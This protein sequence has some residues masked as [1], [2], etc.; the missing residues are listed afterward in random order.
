MGEKKLKR[1]EVSESDSDSLADEI[2]PKIKKVPKQ[3]KAKKHKSKHEKKKNS[4]QVDSDSEVS[5]K[6]RKRKKKKHK[7]SD[8][9]D[10]ED[11]IPNKRKR[12]T[13][14]S[15]NED[16]PNSSLGNNRHSVID[17][18]LMPESNEEA[19][20][21]LLDGILKE[22]ISTSQDY[23]TDETDGKL[24]EDVA[25]LSLE[26]QKAMI[27]AELMKSGE[28]GE[29]SE[30]DA[31]P[32]AVVV[33]SDR[34]NENGE[35]ILADESGEDDNAEHEERSKS[36]KKKKKKDKSRHKG[37]RHKEKEKYKKRSDKSDELVTKH[38]EERHSTI[39]KG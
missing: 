29:L 21:K 36:K 34:E 26:E 37:D 18:G 15:S 3:K 32:D 19:D 24:G 9:S 22:K 8:Y 12:P 38:K 30:A 4:R 35:T 6:K 5:H 27:Q 11:G 7:R 31:T 25:L 13:D 33:S 16:S 20:K 23:P 2:A 39:L 1:K 10:S 17:D 14:T 28:T